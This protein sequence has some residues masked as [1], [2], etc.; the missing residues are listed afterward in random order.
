MK[1]LTKK[2]RAVG[3]ILFMGTALSFSA[4]STGTGEGE[5]NVEESDFKDK[6]P[7][8]HNETSVQPQATSPD[9]TD[10][11]EAYERTEGDKGVRDADNDG[12]ADQ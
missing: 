5:T 12:T 11:D 4:C 9:S 2:I 6:N 1:I 7:D 3:F 10:M 8:E